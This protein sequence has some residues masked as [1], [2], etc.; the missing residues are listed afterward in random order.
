MLAA[1]TVVAVG[2]RMLGKP[3]DT[4]EAASFL[5]LLS[6]RRHRVITGVATAYDGELRSRA[7]ETIVRFRVISKS[8]IDAYV[9]SGEWDGKAGGYA[10]QGRAAT[11][12]PW[13]AGSHAAVVGLPLAET[14]NL[15][16]AAGYRRA[17]P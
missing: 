7:V 10:I 8:E 9:A 2:R 3:A 12:I 4:G 15:L 1:D 5:R 14:L 11:F 17:S 6:G 16:E 13:I